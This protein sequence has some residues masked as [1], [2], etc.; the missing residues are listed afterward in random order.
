M[1]NLEGWYEDF[2][3][4][5]LDRQQSSSA[6]LVKCYGSRFMP[7]GR[8]YEHPT[9]FAADLTFQEIADHIGASEA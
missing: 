5:T 3:L 4:P 2:T 6:R 9:A 7:L 8:S 1:E